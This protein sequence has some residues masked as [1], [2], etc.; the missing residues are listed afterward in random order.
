MKPLLPS[1]PFL[2][3]TIAVCMLITTASAQSFTWNGSTGE[4][5]DIF[6]NWIPKDVPNSR[7][8]DVVFGPLGSGTNVEL[9]SPKTVGTMTFDDSR[10]YIIFGST[11]ELDVSSGSAAITVNSTNGNGAHTI[12][13]NLSLA[14]DVVITNHSTGAFT[15]GGVISGSNGVTKSGAGTVILTGDNIY[16]GGTTINA[17]T[18]QVGNGGTTGG[19][20]GDVTN[21]G[22]LTFNRLDNV[23]FSNA[24]SGTGEVTKEGAGTLTFSGENTYSGFTLIN[25]GI[26]RVGNSLVLQNSTV[27]LLVDDGLDLNGL[28]ATL[29][30]LSGGGDLDLGDTTLTVGNNSENTTHSGVISGTG[31][32]IKTGTGILTF[33]GANTYTGTTTVNAGQLL[34]DNDN[35]NALANSAVT[36]NAGATLRLRS[37]NNNDI[38]SLGSL[39]G[40]GTFLTNG[41]SAEIGGNHTSTTFSGALLLDE[42]DEEA[43]IEKV[44]AGTWT[45]T[46]SGHD[47][48]ELEVSEGGVVLAEVS[49]SVKEIS[50]RNSGHLTIQNTNALTLERIR[51]SSNGATVLIT[52]SSTD[53][54]IQ[55]ELINRDTLTIADGA[56]VTADEFRQSNGQMTI[57]D[58]ASLT[59]EQFHSDDDLGTIAISNA[60]GGTALTVGDSTNSTYE[61]V[62]V[63]HTTGPGS[64][65]KT[66]S[67]R[68]TLTEASTYS[69]TTTIERGV[70]RIGDEL[71]LQNTTVSLDTNDGLDVDDIDATLGGLEGSGN[72]DLGS[73]LLTVGN[74]NADTTY[75]GI[76]SGTG[77]VIKIGTG[78]LT[79]AGQNTYSGATT[80]SEGTLVIDS[81]SP[82]ALANSAVTVDSG[83]T[84]DFS[85]FTADFVAGS[86]AGGGRVV[87]GS[88][89]VFVG[90]NNESTT[91]TGTLTSSSPFDFLEKRGTGTW[92]LGGSGHQLGELR[93][94]AGKLVMDG[95]GD[96]I[97]D[98]IVESTAELT[99]QN[100]GNN[101]D[102]DRLTNSGTTLI[103]G[104]STEVGS[105][106]P[107]TNNNSLTIADGATVTTDD[108][109][110]TSGDTTIVD[111]A[112]LTIGRFTVATSTRRGTIAISDASGGGSALTLGN[113][114]NSVFQGVIED[115]SAGP[116]SVRKIGSGIVSLNNANTYSGGTTI[117]EGT[118]RLGSSTAAGTGTIIIDGGNLD[119]RGQTLNNAISFGASGGGI[120]GTGTINVDLA[121]NDTSQ[122]LTPGNSPGIQNLGADQ[123]WSAF[124]YEW[125]IND[126]LG[127]VAGDDYDQIQIDGELTLTG[128]TSGS[129]LLDILSLTASNFP[130]DVPNFLEQDQS[131]LILTTTTGITGFDENFW[132]LDTSG[133]TS[134]SNWQGQFSLSQVGND[135]QLDYEA[136]PEPSTALLLLLAVGMILLRHRNVAP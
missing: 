7:G 124:T 42:I 57:V 125:E 68:I 74:N 35:N 97:S 2:A 11:L 75:S 60:S 12:N 106:G 43:V 58:Q 117:E 108:F 95:T 19:I 102:L 30:S 25:D 62:I 5:W 129:Y 82:N 128:S 136:I 116:G 107:V 71:T 114:F 27:R 50:V 40:A 113:Q 15:V 8:D 37:T 4:A 63:D 90:G 123:T 83:A 16:S 52:G 67:G 24:I 36:V 91:F 46:G 85:T 22:T 119:V 20:S 100:T 84:L 72:L 28:N 29:G 88:N 120:T 81:D 77:N 105:L 48:F 89:N 121:L 112:L 18:L 3:A 87:M 92:T 131:W 127:T 53:L 115:H 23:S 54:S 110:Q 94:S 69:G 101:F 45:L 130:G 1:S 133:F 39:A 61:G 73:T 126:W 109:R 59:I 78:T 55:D 9:L 65:R 49:G 13:S 34:I 132:T 14:D 41:A 80:I 111:E 93:V 86:L 56:S 33:D 104:P 21:N 134:D 47:L 51:T 32:V 76:I 79:F 6:L 118:L 103:T 64:V 38:V 26:M 135:L 66:G 122:V 10:N 99:I 31:N 96:G 70:L 17:G 44:G 98:V